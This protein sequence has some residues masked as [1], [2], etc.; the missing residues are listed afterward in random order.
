MIE[1]LEFESVQD[2]TTKTYSKNSVYFHKLN[3]WSLHLEVSN[4]NTFILE[5]NWMLIWDFHFLSQFFPT[6]IKTFSDP[7]EPKNSTLETTRNETVII[8]TGASSSPV[9]TNLGLIDEFDLDTI[10]PNDGSDDGPVAVS[11]SLTLS[12]LTPGTV[13]TIDLKGRITACSGVDSINTTTITEC[14]S[15]A[16]V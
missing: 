9:E 7:R 16:H 3:V 10:S 4:A 6:F 13:Y 5:Q 14:T 12:S 11:G 15:K 1:K 2:D 8:V